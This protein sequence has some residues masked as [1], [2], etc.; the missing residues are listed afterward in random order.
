MCITVSR[1]MYEIFVD[2]MSIIQQITIEGRLFCTWRICYF[3]IYHY[4]T[5][6]IFIRKTERSRSFAI[7]ETDVPKNVLWKLFINYSEEGQWQVHPFSLSVNP[8]YLL[9]PSQLPCAHSAKSTNFAIT[10]IIFIV[11]NKVTQLPKAM[12][13]TKKTTVLFLFLQIKLS[14]ITACWAW[15]MMERS[16]FFYMWF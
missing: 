4:S 2:K 5:W 6:Y 1:C 3:I 7:P 16:L 15:G 11:Q 10:K 9:W 13:I 8:G 14:M 12:F